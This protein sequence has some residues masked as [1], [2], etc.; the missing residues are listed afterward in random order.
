MKT[1]LIVL[2]I[3]GYTY[4]AVGQTPT[5]TAP[6]PSPTVSATP[7]QMQGMGQQQMGDMESM[8]RM[9]D[10]CQQ[11][12]QKEKAAMPFI[13]GSSVL[14]GVLLFIALVLLIVLEIQWIK[15]WARLLQA[16]KG[17]PTGSTK[18]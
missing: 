18:E 7:A 12:M 6:A 5:E 16:Q 1:K 9:A 3:L 4:I 17:H 13:I 8:K 2:S 10:M 11:M 14:F 15:Y